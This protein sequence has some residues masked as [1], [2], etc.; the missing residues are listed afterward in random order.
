MDAMRVIG[1][2]P[3]QADWSVV[4]LSF[5]GVRAVALRGA[6]T[7]LTVRNRRD[8]GT[9]TFHGVKGDRTRYDT[10]TDRGARTAGNK[11]GRLRAHRLPAAA[12]GVWSTYRCRVI[13]IDIDNNIKSATYAGLC[14]APPVPPLPRTASAIED[15]S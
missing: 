5:G 12:V 9:F 10:E 4:D 7:A 1:S 8:D 3:V 13:D 6:K 14:I 11:H 2:S 15:K